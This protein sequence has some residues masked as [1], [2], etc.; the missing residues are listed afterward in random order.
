MPVGVK[1]G[2]VLKKNIRILSVF[3]LSLFL[4]VMSL[5]PAVAEEVN[6]ENIYYTGYS[7]DELREAQEDAVRKQY[8][9][10]SNLRSTSWDYHSTKISSK[11][12][13]KATYMGEARGQ[14]SGGTNF[15]QYGGAFGYTD[16]TSGSGSFSISFKVYGPLSVSMGLGS[17]TTNGVGTYS[18]NAPANKYVKLYIYKTMQATLFKNYR[19]NRTTGVT[20]YLG[21]SYFF[22]VYSLRGEVK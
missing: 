14:N 17:A 9:S 4:G 7:D 20:E 6:N 22:S 10:E 3:F 8:Q 11:V 16:R 18:F 12:A 15:G 19:T 13:D 5:V 21:E 1:G 2:L